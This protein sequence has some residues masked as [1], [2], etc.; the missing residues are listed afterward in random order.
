MANIIRG[1]DQI[2][3]WKPII[4]KYFAELTGEVPIS[5]A[6]RLP[7]KKVASVCRESEVA[8][9]EYGSTCVCVCVCV[10]ACVC[11]CVRY[12]MNNVH[13]RLI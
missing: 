2:F 8:V 11:V 4:K 5:P 10:C 1:G 3:K 7:N 6:P 13:V 9:E 12:M